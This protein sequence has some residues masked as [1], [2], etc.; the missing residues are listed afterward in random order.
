MLRL[1]EPTQGIDVGAKAEIHR[2]IADLAATGIGIVLI[3]SDLQ[4]LTALSDRIV[5]MRRGRVVGELTRGEA[6]EEHVVALAAGV[7]IAGAVA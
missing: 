4:E 5:V 7:E 2:L 3:T 6:T 1:D